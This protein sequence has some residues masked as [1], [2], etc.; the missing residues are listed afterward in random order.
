MATR[1][2]EAFEQAIE[3]ARNGGSALDLYQ[4]RRRFRMLYISEGRLIAEIEAATQ[5]LDAAIAAVK[6]TT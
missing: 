4:A 6:E 2:D 1:S 3:V 5:R